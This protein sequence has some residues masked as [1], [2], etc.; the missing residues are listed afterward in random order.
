MFQDILLIDADSI[1]FR[2]A[3]VTTK[4]NEIR[5]GIKRTMDE[6]KKNCGVNDYMCAVK[7]EGN[8][9]M[10]V[11]PNYKGHRK[12]LEPEVKAAVLYGL[13]HMIDEY[14]AV[15]AHDMEADDLVSIWAYEMMDAGREPTIVA[16]DK[17]L[18]QIPGWHYNF[19]KKDPPRYVDVDEANR[20]LMMQCLTGD[21]ADNIKGLKGIGPKKAEK[22][23]EGVPMERRWDKVKAAY[24]EHKASNLE[25][26]YTLLKMLQSW[27]EYDNDILGKYP[28]I[29][30]SK[31]DEDSTSKFEREAAERKHYVPEEP[32]QDGSVQEV[33]DGDPGRTEGN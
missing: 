11:D 28:I 27:P 25:S 30:E 12:A 16:I 17:D 8:F 2:I 7:G 33:S 5:K 24:R 18:L 4:K 29:E 10:R 9:R 13:Q 19:V 3:M 26:D 31:P 15:P 23:L 6:I 14:N 1:Y 22:I 32:S 20:L 21:T